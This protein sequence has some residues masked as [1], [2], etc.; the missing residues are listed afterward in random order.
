LG[1]IRSLRSPLK[2]LLAHSF[3]F[4]FIIARTLEIR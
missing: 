1:Y 3:P 2:M 4:V